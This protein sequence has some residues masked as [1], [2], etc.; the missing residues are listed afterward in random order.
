M[1]K[2]G[3][4]A[5]R[6]SGWARPP[7]AGQ[8]CKWAWEQAERDAMI[9]DEQEAIRLVIEKAKGDKR[10]Y[11]GARYHLMSIVSQ[12]LPCA[13]IYGATT[14]QLTNAAIKA[15]LETIEHWKAGKQFNKHNPVQLEQ[16]KAEPASAEQ[17]QSAFDKIKAN[18]RTA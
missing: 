15:R 5:C 7:S 10:V 16:K 4:R 9:P 14:D 13:N 6:A 17:R 11:G 18:W 8:F 3:L 1:I 12:Y 2:R